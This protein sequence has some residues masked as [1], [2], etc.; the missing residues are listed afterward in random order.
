MVFDWDDVKSALVG[1]GKTHTDA[2]EMLPLLTDVRDAVFEA[3]A[4]HKN[5][6]KCYVI[7]CK[8]DMETLRKWQQYLDA[9]LMVM[10]TPI[11][12]CKERVKE[13]TTREDKQR[14]YTL[15]DEWF[16]NWKGGEEE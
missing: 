5:P 13:D 4:S 7:T 16:K 14:F 11:E 12:I 8:N 3:I 6:G 1:S 10:D 15:I 2:A 9:D